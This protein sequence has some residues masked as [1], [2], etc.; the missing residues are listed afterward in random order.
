MRITA[1][2]DDKQLVEST[3]TFAADE[4]INNILPHAEK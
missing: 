2:L 4:P 3:S 1:R